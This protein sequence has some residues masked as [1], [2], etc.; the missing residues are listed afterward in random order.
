MDAFHANSDTATP[1]YHL[2]LD[3]W[4]LG[5]IAFSFTLF[6]PALHLYVLKRDNISISPLVGCCHGPGS[7]DKV[8]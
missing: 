1:L 5:K 4:K 2:N 6:S 3:A 7:D 8:F